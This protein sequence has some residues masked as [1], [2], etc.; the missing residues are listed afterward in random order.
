MVY[1]HIHIEDLKNINDALSVAVIFE[2]LGYDA[3][4]D[5]IDVSD[6]ELSPTNTE[7]IKTAYLIANQ[8][9]GALQVFLLELEPKSWSYN[10]EVMPRLI[11]IAKSLC[12][13]YTDIL[14]VATV[15]YQKL[16]LVSPFQTFDQQF[17][18]K[19]SIAKML[20]NLKD[21]SFYD[22][23]QLEKMAAHSLNPRQLYRVQHQT[24]KQVRKEKQQLI[25]QDLVQCY[26]REIGRIPLLKRQD[27]I[28]LAQKVQRWLELEQDK[29]SLDSRL[30]REPTDLEWANTT[31][32]SLS[33]LHDAISKG[34]YAQ[35]TLVCSNLRLVVSIAKNYQHRGLEL[36]DLIQHGNFGLIRAT[37]KFDPTKDYKF[38]TYATWWIR[39]AITR[40]ICNESRIIRVPV[41]V[42]E[43]LNKIKKATRQL[44]LKLEHTPSLEEIAVELK[45]SA[46]EVEDLRGINQ[47]SRPRS[48][49]ALLTDN[50]SLADLLHGTDD[51]AQYLEEQWMRDEIQQVLST[52][53]PRY[54][55][56]L[57]LRFGLDGQGERTLQEIGDSCGLTRERIRQI[58]NQAIKQLQLTYGVIKR[59]KLTHGIRNRKCTEYR[60]INLEKKK[61]I[62]SQLSNNPSNSKIDTGME[63]QKSQVSQLFGNPD[64]DPLAKFQERNAYRQ[65]YANDDSLLIEHL[66]NL[67]KNKPELKPKDIIYIVW[68]ISINQTDLYA[69]AHNQLEQWGILQKMFT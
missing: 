50:F 58:Q 31:G 22:L 57:T 53:D 60:L 64:I 29:K 39:Q 23:N 63:P 37:E 20:I 52:L 12:Q 27:E 56:V 6:L 55:K 28:F 32:L 42:Y 4:C 30:H 19:W 54:Q 51:L 48:L 69:I 10:V 14:I 46:K 11:A 59:R 21:P 8:E 33:Q 44:P 17:N 61:I 1:R 15:N 40:G 26:L 47:L 18:V 5:V 13:R 38:S 62:P 43:S 2:L 45:M 16:M 65:C 24:L 66:L 49:D 36:L 25:S 7:A 3:C 68:G 34:R 41:H 67:I 9:K 35:H